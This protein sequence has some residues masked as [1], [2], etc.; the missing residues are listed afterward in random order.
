MLNSGYLA[1]GCCLLW[2][3]IA[4]CQPL[5]SLCLDKVSRSAIDSTPAALCLY[6]HPASGDEL[7]VM[8]QSSLDEFL[9]SIHKLPATMSSVAHTQSRGIM[10][11]RAW[12]RRGFWALKPPPQTIHTVSVSKSPQK[13]R[14]YTFPCSIYGSW[15]WQ[16]A[17]QMTTP[18]QQLLM[19]AWGLAQSWICCRW[20]ALAGQSKLIT[21]R[22][23]LAARLSDVQSGRRCWSSL[24]PY[25]FP[26]LDL[27]SE[28]KHSLRIMLASAAPL[29]SATC[30][31]GIGT[32][33]NSCCDNGHLKRQ[34]K[35]M[36]LLIWS[37]SLSNWHK[38]ECVCDCVGV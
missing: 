14:L 5:D 34:P 24:E 13:C 28:T 27:G 7:P 1:S 32:Q 20:L 12:P 33:D 29:L 17:S 6:E 4:R 9:Y 25:R 35:C 23:P 26:P 3:I 21:W 16:W 31:F 22:H 18:D 15:A 30:C 19:A 10:S 11:L 37:D 2:A 38:F 8:A 36:D